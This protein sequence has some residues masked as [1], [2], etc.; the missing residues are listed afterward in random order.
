MEETERDLARIEEKVDA[1]LE[2]TKKA[3]AGI[4]KVGYIF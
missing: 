4:R 3:K 1:L 2:I